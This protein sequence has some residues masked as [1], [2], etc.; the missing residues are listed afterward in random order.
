[1]ILQSRYP[2]RLHSCEDLTGAGRSTSKMAHPHGWH[3]GAGSWQ[4][5]S[6]P[7][8]VVFSIGLLKYSHGIGAVSQSVNG[9]QE[10]KM[11]AIIPFRMEP[12]KS[13][14]VNSQI[15]FCSHRPA[16]LSM[17]GDYMRE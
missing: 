2:S 13:Y 14:S 4:E 8:H 16:L 15:S 11:K 10:I 1:M 12:Q 3:I 9:P 5:A 17:G 7:C 6:V